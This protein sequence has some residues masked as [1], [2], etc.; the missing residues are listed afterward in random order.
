MVMH[1]EIMKEVWRA[2]DAFARRH[3]YD[4]DAMIEEL[5]NVEQASELPIVD[6]SKRTL[7]R[8]ARRKL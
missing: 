5:K 6:R 2:R 7:R 8:R 1:N 4:I 3:H